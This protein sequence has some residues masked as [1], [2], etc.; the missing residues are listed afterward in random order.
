MWMTC[1]YSLNPLS[2]PWLWTG[3]PLAFAGLGSPERE[4]FGVLGSQGCRWE[5][6]EGRREPDIATYTCCLSS[7]LHLRLTETRV[8]YVCEKACPRTPRSQRV[9]A[10]AGRGTTSKSVAGSLST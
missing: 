1:T 8:S 4:R 6:S 2:R 10:A 9:L 3:C 7:A 5:Q